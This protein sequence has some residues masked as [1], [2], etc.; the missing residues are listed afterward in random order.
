MNTHGKTG[1]RNA[2]KTW[3]EVKTVR[4]QAHCTEDY[5]INVAK[6]SRDFGGMGKY[7]RGLVD[8]DLEA[9]REDL[10]DAQGS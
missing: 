8:A 3:K 4:I 6:R 9:E 5:R 10:R 1:N 2:Q 7:I